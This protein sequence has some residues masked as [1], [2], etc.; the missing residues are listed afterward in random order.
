MAA[1]R[2]IRDGSRYQREALNDHADRI[3][4]LE[5]INGAGGE[6]TAKS[7]V[8]KPDAGDGP[9][10]AITAATANTVALYDGNSIDFAKV[11]AAAL[12]TADSAK[13]PGTPTFAIGAESGGNAIVV[14]ITLKDLAGTTK[15]AVSK[16]TVWISDTAGAAPSGTPP[17]GATSITTGTQLKE[18]T[19][20]VLFEALSNASGV[21]GLT[22]TE[23]TAKSFFVNVAQGGVVASSS[24]VTFA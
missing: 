17:D 5:A 9:A 1:K 11:P 23:T 10:E 14:T 24:A 2:L 20:K 3:D 13:V 22:I 15:A 19:T 7:L 18:L 21:I 4:V 12:A 8:G 6:V 16:A